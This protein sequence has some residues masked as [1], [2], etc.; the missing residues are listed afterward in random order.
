MITAEDLARCQWGEP[1]GRA[2]AQTIGSWLLKQGFAL[3]IGPIA[4]KTFVPGQSVVGGGIAIDPEVA[5]YPGDMLHEAGHLAVAE[6]ATRA[7]MN[8]VGSDPGE[9]MAAIDWSVAAARDCA[10][11]LDVLFHEHGYKGEAGW[12]A[13]TFGLGQPFGVPLLVWYGMTASPQGDSGSGAAFPNM[14]RRLR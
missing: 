13:E 12:L 5:A 4:N 14:I 9:E 3:S 1:G 7:A 2:A 6:P 8:D 11:P 10:I